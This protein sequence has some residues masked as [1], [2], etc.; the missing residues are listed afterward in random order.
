[1]Q[2][3]PGVETIAPTE[4]VTIDRAA[5]ATQTGDGGAAAAHVPA[6][7]KVRYFGDYE[8][9][10]ELGRGGMGVVYEA[11]Q[12]SLNRAVALKMV[13]AGLLAGGDELRRFQNEAEA[14][15]MLDHPG[16]VP[17]FEVGEHEGQP[18]FSMKLV[19]GGSLASLLD[20]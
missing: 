8:I 15:A 3:A 12:T 17:V 18:Y 2:D 13:K 10:R 7:E 16:V 6:V 14:V 11:R 20:C 1:L 5:G 4:D 9:R 19:S